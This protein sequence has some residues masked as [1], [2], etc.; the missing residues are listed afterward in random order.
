MIEIIPFHNNPKIIWLDTNVINDMTDFIMCKPIDKIKKY[1]ASILLEKLQ[2]L[3]NADKIICPFLKQRDEYISTDVSEMSDTILMYLSKGKQLKTYLTENLQM[4]RMMKLYLE[5]GNR[6][7]MEKQDIPYYYEESEEARKKSKERYGL[8]V[9][10]LLT[11]GNKEILD[12]ENE[13][14]FNFL[15]KRKEELSQQNKTFD[16]V[17]CEELSSSSMLFDSG[18]KKIKKEFGYVKTNFEYLSA[19]YCRMYPLIA[20]QKL[21]GKKDV[22]AVLNFLESDYFFAIP[23]EDIFCQLGAKILTDPS[24]NI[25]HG[26]CRDVRSLSLI[27]PYA[28]LIITDKAMKGAI[29][30][31]KLDKKYDTKIFSLNDFDNITKE[32]DKM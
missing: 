28:S 17:L 20:W 30:Q 14:L 29:Q 6:F 26:D 32:L 15:K 19:Y 1:R 3:V 22:D 25:V 27:L 24:R 12:R 2:A 13:Y 16:E 9:T 11:G 23:C 8:S 10:V 5:K 7:N 18:V 21:T 31:L 4:K